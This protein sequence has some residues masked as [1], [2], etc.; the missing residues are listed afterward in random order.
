[1]VQGGSKMKSGQAKAKKTAHSQRKRA[2][3]SRT[4]KKGSV[5]KKPTYGSQANAHYKAKMVGLPEPAEIVRCSP[6]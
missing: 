3:E 4:A 2:R 6:P 1:M 5:A